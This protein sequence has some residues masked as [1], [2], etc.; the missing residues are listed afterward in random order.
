MK[1][2]LPICAVIAIIGLAV[3]T[4]MPK[5]NPAPNFQIQDLQGKT[6]SN[7]NLQNR[8]TLMNFWFPS[9]PGCI[10]EMPKLIQMAQDY[11][12]RNFQI[13]AVAVPIDPLSS[14]QHYTAE[15]KLPFTVMF[16]TNKTVTQSFV[17]TELFPTSVLINKRGEILKTFVGE[18]DFKQL[19]QEVDAELVK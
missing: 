18:P 3:F 7:A 16:D 13:F 12:G 15:R 4:L 19:Y 9:C 17:K 6:I 5:V 8:V 10:T 14:V 1:R 2:I 11:Q